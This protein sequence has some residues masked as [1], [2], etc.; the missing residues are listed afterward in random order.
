MDD[1]DLSPLTILVT[2]DPDSPL[3]QDLATAQEGLAGLLADMVDAEDQ[4]S[5]SQ[6]AALHLQKAIE[7]TSGPIGMVNPGVIPNLNSILLVV[8]AM[9]SPIVGF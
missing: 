9:V 3:N 8:R 2:S 4:E 7:I 5:Q 6:A 1:I